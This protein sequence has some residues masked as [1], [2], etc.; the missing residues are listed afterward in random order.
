M[1]I[2]FRSVAGLTWET[3]VEFPSAFALSQPLTPKGLCGPPMHD[4]YIWYM[5]KQ[6]K[7]NFEIYLP[8][9][10][11]W[12]NRQVNP[13]CAGVGVRAGKSCAYSSAYG[14]HTPPISTT[15]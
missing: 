6:R 15:N 10:P 4:P 13:G 8:A 11:R 5:P 9:F 7:I 12:N 2:S 3:P 14:N 1:R